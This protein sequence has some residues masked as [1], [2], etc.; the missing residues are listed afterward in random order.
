MQSKIETSVVLSDVGATALAEVV[1][2]TSFANT[3][4]SIRPVRRGRTGGVRSEPSAEKKGVTM[5]R[6]HRCRLYRLMQN[7]LPGKDL[8]TEFWDIEENP[9]EPCDLPHDAKFLQEFIGA[10]VGEV[11]RQLDTYRQ[12]HGNFFQGDWS[13]RGSI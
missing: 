7:F 9:C 6:T 1:K 4:V 2:R 10:S 12:E 11:R 3:R 13:L 5:N 8:V